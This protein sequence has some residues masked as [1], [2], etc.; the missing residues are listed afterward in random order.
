MKRT[1]GRSSRS[2]PTHSEP[3]SRAEKIGWRIEHDRGQPV[4]LGRQRR[5]GRSVVVRAR[6]QHEAAARPVHLDEMPGKAVRTDDADPVGLVVGERG[7]A[8]VG[9]GDAAQ[10]CVLDEG[11]VARHRLADAAFDRG[12]GAGI[13]Q[14]RRGGCGAPR[15]QAES[16]IVGARAA[17]T[18]RA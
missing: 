1:P 11:V 3:C 17:V 6:R 16:H 10:A 12:R 2:G 14:A 4:R 8:R 7:R 15:Q 13:G 18:I 9:D 5:P